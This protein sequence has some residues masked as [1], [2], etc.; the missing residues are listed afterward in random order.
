M[1]NP[2]ET[3][4]EKVGRVLSSRYGIRVVCKGNRCCTDG[5][6]IYLPALPDEIP[7]GLMGAIRAFLDHEVGHIV[8]QSDFAIAKRF[9]EKHGQ[10][11]FG[12]LNVLEDLRI[13]RVMRE[14]YAGC[15]INLQAGYEYAVE[16]LREQS[17]ML[18]LFKQITTAMYSRGSCREDLDFIAPDAYS[19]CDEIHNEI[20]AAPGAKDTAEVEKLAE[21]A[22]AVISRHLHPLA[23]LQQQQQE[24]PQGSLNSA[25][26]VRSEPGSAEASSEPSTCASQ[27]DGQ[28]PPGNRRIKSNKDP[29]SDAQGTNTSGAAS[30]AEGTNTDTGKGQ[31]GEGQN[32]SHG[33][34]A[35][36]MSDLAG[37]IE[38]GVAL[39]AKTTNAYRVW[40]TEFDRVVVPRA[41]KADHRALLAEVMPYVGGVRQRLLQSLQA[42]TSCRW[43]GE[44]E[45]GRVDP[46]SLHRLSLH[47]SARVFR[48]KV[49]SRTK[50]TAVL[51]LVDMSSSMRGTKIEL[52]A[53][54]SL[55]FSESLD[56]LGIPSAVV[57][58]STRASDTVKSISC[59]SGIPEAELAK[60]FRFL[61]L[62]HTIFKRFDEPWRKVSGRFTAMTPQ[63]LTP[64][65]ES[66]LFAA[67]I[68]AGRS[69][70]RKIILCLTDGKPVVG[71][72]PEAVTFQHAKDS[73][74]R[75]ERA[76]IEVILI[77]IRES[78]VVHLHSKHV[79]VNSLQQ[80]PG[81]VVRQLQRLLI[82]GI[83]RSRT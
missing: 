63:N 78:C 38:Q 5:R 19:V 66:L 81:T 43:F 23:S 37:L 82:Q 44:Q 31:G 57:G 33:S 45:R 54:T 48:R 25:G 16:K 13:E 40:T 22:W 70:E 76:G 17:A 20:A 2:L 55:V 11:A 12:V 32:R 10:D 68:I 15:G 53:Q 39:H 60:Q 51:L 65:G 18:D 58:F 6:T 28:P 3:V 77:G 52:A 74:A 35:G 7:P 49:R 79:I 69:E 9:A 75:I 27:P 83:E 59:Q 47:T 21:R 56:R 1:T 4:L 71:F 62:E 80:L 24:G 29:A 72:D 50:S 67:R 36:P 42:E 8:G 26:R 14:L 41:G 64:L 46:K 34:P 30:E 73:I 61:P